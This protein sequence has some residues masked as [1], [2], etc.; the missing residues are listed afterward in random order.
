[1]QLLFVYFFFV[2]SNAI[3]CNCGMSI[4]VNVRYTLADELSI[5]ITKIVTRLHLHLYCV[6][7]LNLV[8]HTLSFV[9][10]GHTYNID[11]SNI[12]EF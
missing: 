9:I 1:M 4:Y 2:I 12:A 6:E 11:V 7:T 10:V 5:T 3:D 8:I